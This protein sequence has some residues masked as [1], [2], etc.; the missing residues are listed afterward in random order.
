MSPAG[1]GTLAL[2]A[3]RDEALARPFQPPRCE[4][5][6]RR[7]AV[8]P[9]D[10]R[11]GTWVGTNGS[12]VA[13]ITNAPTAFPDPSRRSRGLLVRDALAAG[14]AAQAEQLVL[15]ALDRERYNGFNLLLADLGR[16]LVLSAADGDVQTEALDDHAAHVLHDREAAPG[17][18][19][20]SDVVLEGAGLA[21]TWSS[22]PSATLRALGDRF[23]ATHEPLP[24]TGRPACRHGDTRGTVASTLVLLDPALP[25]GGLLLFAAGPPCRTP[26][27]EHALPGR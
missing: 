9:L 27:D 21:E 16:A 25:C 17:H 18:R 24:W 7:R 3:N 26:W 13:A 1:P 15:R 11:G 6:G 12:L 2:A 20:E 10:H 23:L 4:A 14:T 8:M 19:L 22:G 5:V